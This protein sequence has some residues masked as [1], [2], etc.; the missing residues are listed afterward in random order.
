[1]LTQQKA[2]ELVESALLGDGDYYVA[3]SVAKAFARTGHPFADVLL[4]AVCRWINTDVEANNKYTGRIFSHA[5]D[6]MY[7]RIAN[8]HYAERRHPWVRTTDPALDEDDLPFQAGLF[9]STD[10][11]YAWPKRV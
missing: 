8:R 2:Y 7:M 1:M 3:D 5:K 4:D 10:Q 11:A 6:A 9:R